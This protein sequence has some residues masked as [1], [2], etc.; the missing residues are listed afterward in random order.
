MVDKISK[1]VSTAA[2]TTTRVETSVSLSEPDAAWA[3][4]RQSVITANRLSRKTIQDSDRDRDAGCL[5][6]NGEEKRHLDLHP[7]NGKPVDVK[8]AAEASQVK[9]SALDQETST[10]R[11]PLENMWATSE[12]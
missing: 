6:D 7:S 8:L 12:A 4:E 5:E 11:S 3:A 1:V 2:S 9:A 10:R